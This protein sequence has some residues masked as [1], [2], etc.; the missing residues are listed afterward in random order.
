M[1]FLWCSEIK[2]LHLKRGWC[3]NT[4]LRSG[5][6][7]DHQHEQT[8]VPEVR[9]IVLWRD[10]NI[11]HPLPNATSG[12][13]HMATWTGVPSRR[14]A[15]GGRRP[16]STA[17]CGR[18]CTS[19]DWHRHDKIA[20]NCYSRG[21]QSILHTL[22]LSALL[23]DVQSTFPLNSSKLLCYRALFP[24]H[25]WLNGHE[26]EQTLRDG[27]GQGSLVCCSPWGH[28]ESDRT[29]PLNNRPPPRKPWGSVIWGSTAGL[30]LLM[31]AQALPGATHFSLQLSLA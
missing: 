15:G 30:Q 21:W 23:Y 17:V 4:A 16:A 31:A 9:V 3:R 14:A 7:L 26:S 12:V 2:G 29:E 25:H 1:C 6:L 5:L 27:K 11:P 28:K 13:C 19:S 22:F 24:W 20:A 10:T 18:G 8:N